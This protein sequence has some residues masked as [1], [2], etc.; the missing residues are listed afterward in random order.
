MFVGG[1]GLGGMGWNVGNE[2]GCR[3]GDIVVG[4]Y[5]GEKVKTVQ[6]HAAPFP[7]VNTVLPSAEMAIDVPKAILSSLL[8]SRVIVPRFEYFPPCCVHESPVRANAHHA[9]VQFW[10]PGPPIT[11]ISPVADK[12]VAVP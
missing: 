2:V 6:I 10:S 8:F 3:V 12:A 9:P 1:V 5:V 7:P 11:R 4:E